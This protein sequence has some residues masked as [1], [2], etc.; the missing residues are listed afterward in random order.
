MTSPELSKTALAQMLR[1]LADRVDSGADVFEVS[2]ET[3]NI[4][5]ASK[6]T[7]TLWALPNPTPADAELHRRRVTPWRAETAEGTVQWCT[8]LVAHMR[9]PDTLCNR[10]LLSDGTCPNDAQHRRPVR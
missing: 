8:R 6:T 4:G 10:M 5:R 9:G 3:E 7:I 2:M 1:T